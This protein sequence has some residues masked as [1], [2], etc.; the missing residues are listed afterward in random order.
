MEA[1]NCST[2]IMLGAALL[3]RLASA[4]SQAQ[5]P[6]RWTV[7]Y[8]L[9]AKQ[10]VSIDPGRLF[11]GPAAVIAPNGDWLVS[12]QDGSDHGG[13]D[14][15]VSQVR[16]TDQGKTWK[17]D[18]I[19][20][21]ERKDGF[22]GRNPAYGITNPGQLVLVVQR[23]KPL[24]VGEKFLAGSDEG[25]QASVYL[26][27]RDNGKTYKSRGLVDSEVP[28]RHQGST[29]A[30]I[31]VDGTLYMTAVT[32]AVPP[33][34]I[35]LYTTNNPEN[36]WQFS[37]WVFRADQLPL[38]YV[39]Y[40]SIIERRD[41]SLLAQSVYLGRNFQTVSRDK[42]KTWSAPRE[43]PDLKIRN[44]PDLD[45]A[46]DVLVVHG[47]GEDANSYV[48]YFSPDEGD[49]WGLPIVLDRYGL[50]GWGGYGASIRLKGGGLFIVFSTDAGP[51]TGKNRGKPDVRGV[52]LSDVEIRRPL[53]E[54]RASR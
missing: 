16:S 31:D 25:I 23:W 11:H 6:A 21:D 8:E 12:Y 40:P 17:R 48:V 33:K 37:G 53:R 39:S 49:T 44:N 38:N 10:D 43:L 2:K 3:L 27:S 29:S 52:F 20:Y 46:G 51:R 47:R 18:G 30:I 41:G 9:S 15:V 22:F 1:R 13:I 7:I 28:L 24:P 45:Y 42:G 5:G 19:V 14:A 50:R 36:G 35:T 4:I 54:E 26:T 34:G 32:M